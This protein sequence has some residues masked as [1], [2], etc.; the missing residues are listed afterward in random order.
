MTACHDNGAVYG[1]TPLTATL[2]H[3]LICEFSCRNILSTSS[4]SGNCSGSN[5]ITCEI[6]PKPDE[7]NRIQF[8]RFPLGITAI[9]Q[10]NLVSIPQGDFNGGGSHFVFISLLYTLVYL[11]R[12]ASEQCQN[13]VQ[14]LLRA[15]TIHTLSQSKSN[16]LEFF[17]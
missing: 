9:G 12:F 4:P 13:L 15:H 17:V 3:V 10:T 11:I 16:H 5:S 14:T 7:S 1:L 8:G 6:K 2:T